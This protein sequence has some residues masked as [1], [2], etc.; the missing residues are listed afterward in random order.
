MNDQYRGFNLCGGCE[1]FS[2][3]SDCPE[4]IVFQL[5]NPL[6]ALKEIVAANRNKRA[7]LGTRRISMMLNLRNQTWSNKAEPKKRCLCPNQRSRIEPECGP[8]R[9]KRA[10]IRLNFPA[11]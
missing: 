1:P 6:R 11:M 10:E 5:V 9:F 8:L 3:I 2:D 7:D 4:A